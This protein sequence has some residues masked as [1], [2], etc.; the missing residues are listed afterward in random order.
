MTDH[1]P[2]NRIRVLVSGCRGKMGAEVCKTVDAAADLVLVGGYDPVVTQGNQFVDAVKSAPAFNDLDLALEECRPQVMVEFTQP[3]V[4]A[5]NLETAL[6]AGVDCVLGT[7]GVPTETLDTLAQAAPEGTGL[8]YAPNYTTGAVLMMAASKLAASFFEDVEIIEYHHNNKKDSPSG[9]A[10]ATAEMITEERQ[11]K[12]VVSSAPGSET[13]LPG[14]DGARG[15]ELIDSDVHI[16]SIRSNGYM[17]SQEIIFGSPGQILSIR[18]DSHERSAYMPG[19]LL[20]IR[21]VGGL[22]GLVI[23]LEELMQL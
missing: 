20:A 2:E 6:N 22:S 9:T 15:A 8:F 23:G 14:L 16:H 17:A 4:A 12:G 21:K 13:E 10:V 1:I 18:H 7:S 3:N 5:V 11:A 19:V